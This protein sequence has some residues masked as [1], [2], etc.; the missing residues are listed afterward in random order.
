MKEYGGFLPI[1]I[2]KKEYFS[3][4]EERHILRLNAARYAYIEACRVGKFKKIWLPV[5]MCKSVTDAFGKV[6]DGW[7]YYNVNH[8]F[9]PDLDRI[10]ETDCILITNYYGQKNDDFYSR[11]EEKFGNIIFDNT[12]SFFCRPIMRHNVYNVYSPR[13]FVGVSDGAYLIGEDVISS[14]ILE[15]DCS[16]CRASYLMESLEFGTNACYRK[17]LDAEDEIS[18]A[19]A[20]SMSTLTKSLLGNIDYESVENKRTI[21]Y[22]NMCWLLQEINEL[23]VN[24]SA[25]SPMIYPLLMKNDLIRDYLVS[26]KVYVPQWWKVVINNPLSNE[27][28][29][30][31]SKYLLPLPID[32]RYTPEDMQCIADIVLSFFDDSGRLEERLWR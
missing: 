9:E 21:N 16:G 26:Q 19:G 7:A 5:Y 6:G 12:Q 28:E 13:K 11:M 8:F 25:V 4:I 23:D 32:Q 3:D 29:R 17:Y 20:R 10:P 14:V 24:E 18:D 31:V 1:D 15:S 30:Y 22:K 2:R 27:W